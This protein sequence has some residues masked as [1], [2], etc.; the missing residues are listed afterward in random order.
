[1]KT[2]DPIHPVPVHDFL[3][4]L[5]CPHMELLHIELQPRLVKIPLLDD[6]FPIHLE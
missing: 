1:M 5:R 2:P 4:C 6:S 3:P